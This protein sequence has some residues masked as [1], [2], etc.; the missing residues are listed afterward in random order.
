MAS[1]VP[2]SSAGLWCRQLTFNPERKEGTLLRNIGKHC[3]TTRATTQK[4]RLIRYHTVETSNPGFSFVENI[5]NSVLRFA[6]VLFILFFNNSSSEE[7]MRAR[8]IK[9]WFRA[10]QRMPFSRTVSE[11]GSICISKGRPNLPLFIIIIIIA[12]G[13]SPCDS[14]PTLIQTKIKIHKT[15]MIL[16]NFYLKHLSLWEEFSEI[17]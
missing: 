3:T 6:I 17:S 14:S 10:Y 8:L 12:I 1:T 9:I 7:W 5:F 4:N 15:T 11:K 16:Y 2:P 13:L